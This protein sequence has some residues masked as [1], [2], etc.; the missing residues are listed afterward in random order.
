MPVKDGAIFQN[1]DEG[2]RVNLLKFPAPLW[3]AD[4]GGPLYRHRLGGDY[5]RA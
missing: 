2:D 3:H 5:A 1:I 4:D